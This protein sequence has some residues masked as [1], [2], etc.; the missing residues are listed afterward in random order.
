MKNYQKVFICL[1]WVV[2]SMTFGFGKVSAQIP[3]KINYQGYLTDSTG[4]PVDETVEMSFVIYDVATEGNAQWTEKQKVKVHD[5]IY[6]VMLGAVNPIE[7]TEAI[8][9]YLGVRVGNDDE[10]T[11]RVELTSTMYAL[12]TSSN[13]E[14]LWTTS[15]RGVILTG[16]SFTDLD[17]SLPAC[18]SGKEPLVLGVHVGPEVNVGATSQD[19][20]NLPHWAVSVPVYQRFSSGSIKVSLT[21]LALGPEH[22]SISLPAG[23]TVI[24]PN[25]LKARISLLGGVTA[26]HR[27]EF[28][29][30]ISGTCGTA[31]IAEP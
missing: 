26:S 9:Y 31:F 28:N 29:V 11:P 12:F 6:N 24:S 27:F 21:A 30:H 10:M 2:V 14:N 25:Q 17:F 4:N 7:L 8:P 15:A 13:E 20:V 16:K 23:Q 3:H 18:P 1:I 19:V 5:G 22:I